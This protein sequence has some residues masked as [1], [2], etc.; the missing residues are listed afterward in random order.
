MYNKNV[1]LV[2]RDTSGERHEFRATGTVI[3]PDGYLRIH[4]HGWT[5]ARF[6]PNAWMWHKWEEIVIGILDGES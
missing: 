2:V 5:V 1:V 3:E 4:N 6:A